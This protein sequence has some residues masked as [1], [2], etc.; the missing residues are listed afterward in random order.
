M[1][2]T[3]GTARLIF[4][5]KTCQLLDLGSKRSAQ[6][7]PDLYGR[8]CFLLRLLSHSRGHLGWDRPGPIA[9]L[10][11]H[12]KMAQH[13]QG[14]S[15]LLSQSCFLMPLQFYFLLPWPVTCSSLGKNPKTVTAL[16]PCSTLDLSLPRHLWASPYCP[17]S[18]LS[19]VCLTG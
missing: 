6:V 16:L 10:R 2:F 4:T 1:V 9:A 19:T 15:S 11:V 5:Q 17:W 18:T 14:H 8:D 12:S 7:S 13:K 3:T